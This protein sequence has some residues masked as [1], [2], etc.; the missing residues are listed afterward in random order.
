M[1]KKQVRQK[2]VEIQERF[3]Y[4][5]DLLLQSRKIKSLTAFCNQYG[6]LM[7]RYS[8]IRTS[9]RSPEKTNVENSGRNYKF[10]DLDAIAYLVEDYGISPEWILTGKGGMF[11]KKGN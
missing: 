2:S 9:L 4:A 8:N 11:T 7:H 3:F 10:I 1:E 5:I 6:L